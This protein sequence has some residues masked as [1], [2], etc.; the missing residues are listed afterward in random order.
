M[1]DS[2]KTAKRRVRE[3]RTISQMVALYCADNHDAAV[4][5]EVAHC[6]EAVCPDCARIDAYAVLRTER[7]RKMEVKTSCEECGNHCYAPAA[8]EEI[9]QVM[10]YAGPRML[11]KHP[12]AAV[13]H[14][15]GK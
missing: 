10:R 7:C 13:R 4:R 2:P 1:D 6:G 11:K 3:K 14:L 12:V 5:T 9:K 8:R 15:M